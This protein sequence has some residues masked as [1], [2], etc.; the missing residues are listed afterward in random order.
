MSFNLAVLIGG[1]SA[2]LGGLAV[3]CLITLIA[4][5]VGLAG[6]VAL[7]LL[8]ATRSRPL[9]AL[10]RGYIVFFR[11]TPEM[12]LIFWAYFCMPMA[13]GWQV[14]GLAAGSVTLGLVAAAYYAEILRAGIEAVP[15]GQFEAARSLGLRPYPVWTRVILPQTVV[16]VMAPS[17]NYLTELIKNTT[18]LAAIG[19][20]ELAFVAYNMGAQTYR[21]FE[22]ITAIGVGYFI[23][24]F[25]ISLL[26]RSIERRNLRQV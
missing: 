20:G 9:A 8:R 3:T 22:F 23:L 11:T 4:L 26:A 24:I 12:V 15:R 16:V 5:A 14:S 6:A 21:Y 19:V 10:V 7:Q 1:E 2:L 18:L 25:P 17:V 13:L